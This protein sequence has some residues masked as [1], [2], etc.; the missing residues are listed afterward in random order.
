M[1]ESSQFTKFVLLCLSFTILLY[2]LN[3]SMI[4]CEYLFHYIY[5]VQAEIT[6]GVTDVLENETNPVTLSCQAIGEPVPII[7]WYSDGTM[8]NVSDTSKYNVSSTV[9]DTEIT[10]LFT[11]M[12]TQ[13][14]DAGIY[15]CEAENFLGT[16]GSSGILTVN[17]E[18]LLYLYVFI[19]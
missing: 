1:V 17:G 13:S 8:I 14:S 6:D 18:Y 2:V 7:I 5:V 12:F 9:N 10:N 3:D 11:I 15:I 4:Q 19:V 16:N